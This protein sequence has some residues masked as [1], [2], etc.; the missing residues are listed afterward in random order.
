MQDL[1]RLAPLLTSTEGEAAF[2]LAFDH[3]ETNRPRVRGTV[4]AELQVCCQRCLQSMPL[5]VDA[6][7]QLSPVTGLGE[8]ERLPAEYE[9][10]LLDER[11]LRPMDLVEDELIL[12]IPPAPRH[13]AADC[14]VDLADYRQESAPE[15]SQR[16]ES[17]FAALRAL[18]RD[19]DD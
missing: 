7:F 19:S 6:A 14:G 12:A 13:A 2:T 18:K 3:D 4:R 9:P 15:A 8:A 1:A 11:L 5:A 10:L 16:K 17:P